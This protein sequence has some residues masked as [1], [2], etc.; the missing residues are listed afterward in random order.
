MVLQQRKLFQAPSADIQLG[1]ST[2]NCHA[3]SVFVSGTMTVICSTT[4]RAQVAQLTFAGDREW[5]EP[6]SVVV[7]VH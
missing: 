4:W 7:D 2:T 6:N 1:C 3:Y 5:I